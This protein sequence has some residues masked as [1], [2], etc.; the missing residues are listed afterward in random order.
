MWIL[1]TLALDIMILGGAY[2]PK[3]TASRGHPQEAAQAIVPG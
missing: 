3:E 1:H 2:H